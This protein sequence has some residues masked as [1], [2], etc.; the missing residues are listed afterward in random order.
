M[1]ALISW[2]GKNRYC[3][4]PSLMGLVIT[5]N[6]FKSSFASSLLPKV[7]QKFLSII[8]IFIVIPFVNVLIEPE[9][10]ILQKYVIE[11][12]V[13]YVKELQV[14]VLQNNTTLA[15]IIKYVK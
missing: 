4:K 7:F 5:N 12:L 10:Q 6:F 3:V 13:R 1:R 2:D 8:L 11:M 15:N 9:I 14:I